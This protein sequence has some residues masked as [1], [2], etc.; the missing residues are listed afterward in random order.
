MRMTGIVEQP[1]AI[2]PAPPARRRRM[3]LGIDFDAVTLEEAVERVLQIARGPEGSLILTP[4]VDHLIRTTRDPEFKRICQQGAL[5]VADG[6]PVVWASRLLQQALPERV[7]G[8][9]LMPM[10][11]VA[12]AQRGL[13]YFFLG[14]SPGDAAKAAAKIAAA[15]GTDGLC[16]VDC[17]PF[18]FERDPAYIDALVERINAARPDI[19]FVGLGS[20]KQEKLMAAL[21]G[22]VHA[23]AMMA[24]GITFSYVAGSLK[25][26]PRPIQRIGLEWL[27]RLAW[28]PRRLWRR[29]LQNLLLFPWLIGREALHLLLRALLPGRAA[30]R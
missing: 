1:R 29:Y 25:R 7:A 6:I 16:G 26:A 18:G 8:S 30:T 12:A 13:R 17:P 19:L 2:A 9:D 11:A 5:V 4:N 15:A 10:S 20:P 14:G 24:V 27:W 3:L 28:E 21:R 23:A 22:R